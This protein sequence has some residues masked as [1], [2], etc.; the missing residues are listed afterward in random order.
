MP[1]RTERLTPDELRARAKPRKTVD[2]AAHKG[3]L[4]RAP[5]DVP[6][7]YVVV[8]TPSGR[9]RLVAFAGTFAV[10]EEGRFTLRGRAIQEIVTT[11]DKIR[12]IIAEVEIRELTDTEE[13][14]AT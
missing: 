1:D 6:D 7:G 8:P 3:K 14:D 5:V 13:S 10:S 12:A 2:G 11:P 9:V 4:T